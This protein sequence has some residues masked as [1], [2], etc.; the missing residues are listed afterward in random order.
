MSP[1]TFT[2][3][4]LPNMMPLRKLLQ[5]RLR[6]PDQV[7]D[8]FQQTLLLAFARR[9]QLRVESKFRS[10]LWSIAFNEIRGLIRAARPGFS[11]DEF[12]NLELPDHAPGPFATCE[13]SERAQWLY[14]AMSALSER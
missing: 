8:V 14:T 5:A 3:L 1:D 6:A 2:N 7:E 4:L 12:P 9:D 10:W 11:L 13:Q